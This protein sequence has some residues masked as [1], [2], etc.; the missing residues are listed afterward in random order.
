MLEQSNPGFAQMVDFY[1]D[2]AAATTHD[3]LVQDEILYR[4]KVRAKLPS[5]PLPP[6]HSSPGVEAMV[7]DASNF[8]QSRSKRLRRREAGGTFQDREDKSPLRPEYQKLI[9]SGVVVVSFG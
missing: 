4:Q 6:S 2:T 1:F 8:N 5:S 9:L 7:E 3:S